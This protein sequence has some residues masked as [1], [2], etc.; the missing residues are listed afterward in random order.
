MIPVLH[1]AQS[2]L[3]GHPLAVAAAAAL[4]VGADF[5]FAAWCWASDRRAARKRRA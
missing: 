3:D 1:H 4:V 5:A 2:W